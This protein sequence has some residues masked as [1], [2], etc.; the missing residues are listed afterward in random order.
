MDKKLDFNNYPNIIVYTM[1]RVGSM[2]MIRTIR[3]AIDKNNLEDCTS[4]HIHVLNDYYRSMGEEE[5]ELNK[6]GIESE[7]IRSTN[8][9]KI[10]IITI[11]RNFYDQ[12]IS[13]FILR[14][15]SHKSLFYFITVVKLNFGTIKFFYFFKLMYSSDLIILASYLY[16]I[17]KNYRIV[18]SI[19][20]V[21][22]STIQR[23]ISNLNYYLKP[24]EKQIRKNKINSNIFNYIPQIIKENHQIQLKDIK[25]LI[26]KKFNFKVSLTSISNYIKQLGYT[27]KLVSKKYFNKNLDEIKEKE[28]IFKEH[29]KTK[30]IDNFISIDETY[31]YFNE[32]FWSKKGEKCIISRKKKQDKLSM[33]MVI[34]NKEIINYHITSSP[35]NK[36]IYMDF[37][38]KLPIKNKSLIM[39]NV[40]FHR[41]KDIL[42]YI[43][44]Y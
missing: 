14:L 2:T 44:L 32:T 31:F 37:I 30:N 11:V 23:W 16:N 40:S 1:G 24:K 4:H 26:F 15:A 21:S 3:I 13:N 33:I 36:E 29:I 10:L 17:H 27:R 28:I 19:I 22:K 25:E 8:G 5:K 6:E 41:N 7:T 12:L 42:N 18:S 38:K 43:K 9:K 39:D 35:I 20:R 34:S